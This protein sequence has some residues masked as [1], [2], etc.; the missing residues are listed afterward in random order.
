MS[1]LNNNLNEFEKYD[2]YN[3]PKLIDP[4]FIDEIE[5][6]TIIDSPG[7][8]VTNDHLL[9]DDNIILF[10]HE[11]DNTNSYIISQ[12]KNE[13]F[14]PHGNSSE[15]NKN[16]STKG[17]TES[18]KDGPIFNISKTPKNK[19]KVNE[20]TN[21]NK[22]TNTNLGKK[23]KE[24]KER[25]NYRNGKHDKFCYDNLTRRVKPKLFSSILNILNSSINKKLNPKAYFLKIVQKINYDTNTEFNRNLLKYKLKD[26]FSNKIYAKVKHYKLEHNKN[27][28]DKI[29]KENIQTKTISILEKT[30]L[31]CLQHFR[32][33]IYYEE[34][35]GLEEEYQNVIDEMI[36]KGEPNDYMKKFKEFL[37]IYEDYYYNKKKIKPKINKKK[38]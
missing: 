19:D 13:N 37:L 35:K 34:L 17:A 27:L 33:S 1:Y 14:F 15:S 3:S 32:G 4:V 6:I 31:E 22:I 28:I 21:T 20:I 5:S 18:V 10:N 8:N 25:K 23:R 2:D 16:A 7:K 9:L 38:E 36:S 26:I 30:L 24:K 29:Y 12:L 11:N